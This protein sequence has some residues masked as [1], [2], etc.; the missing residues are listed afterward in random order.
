MEGVEIIAAENG[1]SGIELAREQLPDLIIC[2]VMMPGMD[3]HSVVKALRQDDKTAQIPFI[4]LTAKA[5]ESDR[6]QGMELGADYY[7][8]KPFLFDNFLQ[9]IATHLEKKADVARSQLR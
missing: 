8:T 9:V 5:F 1:K 4:F 7:M 6:K 2:D 3:G